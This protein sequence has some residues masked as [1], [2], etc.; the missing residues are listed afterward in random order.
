MKSRTTPQ[1]SKTKTGQ[2]A[3]PVTASIQTAKAAPVAPPVY[4]PQP[5]P[6][7]LQRKMAT[8][9]PARDAR[10]TP[11]AP[12]VYRPQQP[13]IQTKSAGPTH[14]TNPLHKG[15][16]QRHPL[17]ISIED[18]DSIHTDTDQFRSVY[19]VTR[20][21]PEDAASS[22]VTD[23]HI[24][25]ERRGDHQYVIATTACGINLKMHLGA[26]G[27]E[28]KCGREINSE[29]GLPIG[30]YRPVAALTLGDAVGMFYSQAHAHPFESDSYNCQRFAADL[31]GRLGTYIVEAGG[32]FDAFL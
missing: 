4:R 6:K 3:R 14:R 8:T 23:I 13:R 12:P 10:K 31:A 25:K 30:H 15:V 26:A 32:D 2:P 21:L 22:S 17:T 7:V 27:A 24:R 16:I 5:V 1:N 20:Y 19:D 29:F 11:Q 9:Q 18:Q 28:I